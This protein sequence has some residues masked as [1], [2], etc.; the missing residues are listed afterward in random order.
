[1][2]ASGRARTWG[3][4]VVLAVAL[5]LVACGAIPTD[6]ERTLARIE[7]TGVLLAGAA[8]RPP[9]VELPAQ[10]GEPPGGSEVR[11]VEDFAE[12][13]GA[14][15]TWTIAGEEELVRLM[16]AGELDVMVGGLSE[17]N[18]YQNKVA[19][20]RP[21]TRSTDPEGKTLKHVM[22]VRLGENALLSRLEHFLDEAVG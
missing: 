13:L 21:Y 4:V 17:Q 5:P 2:V 14:E 15:V 9:W 6:P 7:D 12:Q 3:W 18:P 8:P 16:E 22:A 11:L 19:F 20:T 1:M 10:A